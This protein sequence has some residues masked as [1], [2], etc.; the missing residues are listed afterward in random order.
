MDPLRIQQ[1][2][3]C[4]T[5]GLSLPPPKS[6][7]TFFSTKPNSALRKHRYKARGPCKVVEHPIAYKLQEHAEMAERKAER[8]IM[9]SM[10]GASKF[11]RC[12]VTVYIVYNDVHCKTAS[13]LASSLCYAIRFRAWR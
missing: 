11:V 5:C 3:N 2:S 12:D 7:Q 13:C 8:R 4:T 6:I 9:Q 1:W 10:I